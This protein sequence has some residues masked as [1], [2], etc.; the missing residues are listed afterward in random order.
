L[1]LGQHSSPAKH[2]D[3]Q[4]FVPRWQAEQAS[5]QSASSQQLPSME[6]ST[7]R[8]KSVP[9]P[10]QVIPSGQ[11]RSPMVL[12]PGQTDPPP[13]QQKSLPDSPP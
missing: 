11:H 7:H 4:V 9:E 6:R 10:Q 8:L 1:P 12:A 3:S 5:P 2:T 13:S